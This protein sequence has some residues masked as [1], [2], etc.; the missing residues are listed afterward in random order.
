MKIRHSSLPKLALCGQYQ[1]APGDSSAAAQRGTRLDAIFREAWVT[2]EIPRDLSDEDAAVVM[3]TVNALLKCRTADGQ[4]VETGEK[5]CKVYTPGIEHVGTAD[6]VCVAGAFLADMKTGQV[7]DYKAQMAA[8]AYG[9][10]EEH[11]AVKW[12]CHLLFADQRKIVTHVFLYDE[13]QALV[14]AAIANVGSAPQIND[15]CGWCAHSLTCSAR[16]Q[17][18][19]AA[20][21]TTAD[22]LPTLLSDPAKLGEFLARCKTFDAFREAAE[23]EA[24][25]LLGEGVEVPGWRLQK[26]RISEFVDAEVL[27]NAVNNGSISATDVILAYGPLSATKARK[28]WAEVPTSKKE[29]KPALVSNK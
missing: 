8:Y 16:I 3:W 17:A 15:Y 6:A 19:D 5:A 24:R 28:L 13:A 23:T 11:L 9:L 25:R 20:L 22:L 7:Y 10:M 12:T 26:P 21:A 4:I 2:G 27:A 29:S 18:K 14:E 1:S